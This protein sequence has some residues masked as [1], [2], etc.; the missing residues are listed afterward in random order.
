MRRS[1]TSPGA[2]SSGRDAIHLRVELGLELA[3]ARDARIGRDVG[4][5][6]LELARDPYHEA[7]AVDADAL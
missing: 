7:G 6:Q 4:M 1:R 5:R 3:A 2:T